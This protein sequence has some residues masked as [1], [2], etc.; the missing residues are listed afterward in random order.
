M[1][2]LH[3]A[4]ERAKKYDIAD[5]YLYVSAILMSKIIATRDEPLHKARPA[6][7][8][9]WGIPDLSRYHKN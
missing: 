6:I 9:G 7:Y 8:Y 3:L 5:M 1:K 4:V 2:T